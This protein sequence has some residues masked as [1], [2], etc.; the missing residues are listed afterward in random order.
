M[1]REELPR[2][3]TDHADA[4]RVDQPREATFL[5]AFDFRCQILCGFFGHAIE[6]GNFVFLTRTANPDGPNPPPAPTRTICG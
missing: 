6:S 1:F 4:Q 5:T 2:S 3:F